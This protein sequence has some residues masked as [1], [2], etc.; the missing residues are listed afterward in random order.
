MYMH[1]LVV[2]VQDSRLVPRA[3][4]NEYIWP[5]VCS[6]DLLIGRDAAV[7]GDQLLLEQCGE[8]ADED[9]LLLTHFVVDVEV[10]VVRANLASPFSGDHDG[11]L[12]RWSDVADK[13]VE[14][15]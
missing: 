15:A 1:G 9:F 8:G 11:D 14:S 3:V 10:I 12:L 5:Y 13:H 7:C 2:C 4:S 6:F